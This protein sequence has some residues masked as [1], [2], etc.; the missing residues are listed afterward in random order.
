M[1]QWLCPSVC[2]L[3]VTYCIVAKRYVEQKKLRR[4]KQ[5]MAYGESNGHVTDDVTWPRIGRK[6]KVV[7][8]LRLGPKQ[9]YIIP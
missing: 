5:E 9:N 8:P 2:R 6:V 3:S 1:L 7:I 4:S